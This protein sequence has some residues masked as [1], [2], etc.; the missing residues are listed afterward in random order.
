MEEGS[1]VRD[2]IIMQDTMI[3]KN[4]VIEKAIV[5]ENV[6][7]QDHVVMG[8][9]EEVPNI[10]KPDI[11]TSGIVTVGECS[12]IPADVQIGKNTAISGVTV[13]EDYVDGVLGSGETLT[14]AGDRA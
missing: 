6:N 3:G 10:W 9:G 5:A 11:Y 14:K 12:V 13:K 4:C 2:S 8:I 1:I 7:I